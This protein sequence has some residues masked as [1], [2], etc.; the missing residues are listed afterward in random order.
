VTRARRWLEG[1]TIRPGVWSR[2]YE[3]GTNR[4]IYGDRDGSIR[5][6]LAEISEER[7]TGYDWELRFP[8]IV[9]ALERDD[10]RLVGGIDALRAFDEHESEPKSLS[11][12]EQARVVELVSQVG[13]EGRWADGPILSTATFVKNCDLLVRA[14]AEPQ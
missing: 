12:E 9:R 3:I 5:Y 11:E 2:L 14:L 7:R 4:P 6:Q 10:A 1:S 8:S 13:A